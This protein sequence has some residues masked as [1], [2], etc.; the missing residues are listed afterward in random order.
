MSILDN[1][2]KRILVQSMRNV[3]ENA[4]V[5][6]A[7]YLSEAQ[8]IDAAEFVHENATYEQLLNV[9]FNPYKDTKY[10]PAHVLEGAAAILHSACMTGRR[11]IGANAIAEG[12]AILMQK[13]GCVI[14]ESMLDAAYDAAVKGNGLQVIGESF[15][16]TEKKK[17]SFMDKIKSGAKSAADAT[18]KAA[19]KAAD[20]TK[21]AG[22]KVYGFGK[23]ALGVNDFSKAYEAYKR[24]KNRGMWGKW[25]EKDKKDFAEMRKFLGKGAAK[26]A[27]SAAVLAGT[28]Y[29]I[30]KLVDWKKKKKKNEDK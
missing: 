6:N 3:M 8:I 16:L 11:T 2:S 30:K 7:A 19:K 4:V 1:T 13:T 21:Y 17:E 15:V 27:A 25:R 28:A 10:L 18:K 29:G 24:G 23:E 9:A 22:K 5:D 12:A 26:G 20:A 14:T